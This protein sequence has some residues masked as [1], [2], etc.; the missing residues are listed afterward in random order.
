VELVQRGD[1]REPIEH[2]ERDRQPHDG[3]GEERRDVR[4][5]QR[6]PPADEQEVAGSHKEIRLAPVVE[7]VEFPRFGQRERRRDEIDELDPDQQEDDRGV[8]RPRD[9]DDERRQPPADEEES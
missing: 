3:H 6:E 2:P 4:P 1:E 7:R 9:V 8:Q 5:D